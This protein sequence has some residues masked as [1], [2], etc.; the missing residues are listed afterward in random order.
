MFKYNCSMPRVMVQLN[1]AIGLI[2]GVVVLI[3]GLALIPT[4]ADQVDNV[5]WSNLSGQNLG[6]AP[7]LIIFGYVL[8]VVGVALASMFMSFK[9]L[10]H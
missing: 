8:G 2:V 7:L 5:E 1:T 9:N 3:I 6:F 10:K 4:V